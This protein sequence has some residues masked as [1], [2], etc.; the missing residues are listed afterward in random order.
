[1]YD[2]EKIKEIKIKEELWDKE[3]VKK[4]IERFPERK[5]EFKT[6]SSIK[7]KNVYT[8]SDIEGLDY[9]KD[10]SFPG[11]YPF[12]RGVYPNM[13]RGRIWTIRQ[14]AGFGKAEETSGRL[15]FLDNAGQTGLN[16]VFDMPTHFALD[17]DNPLA[18]GEVGRE[19]VA[20]DT[21]E[22]MECL[23]EGIPLDQV[24][25]SLITIGPAAATVLAMYITI[26]EKKG[27]PPEKLAGTLQND[28]ITA[29]AASGA[30]KFEPEVFVRLALDVSEYCIRNMPKWYPLSIVGYHI[31]EAG[32]NAVQELAFT[33][34]SGIAYVKE[35][36]NR[37]LDIDEI[38]PKISFFFGAHNNFF[39]EI[40]KFRAARRM[41][42]QIMKEWFDAKDIRSQV[43]KFHVQ[44]CG[45]TLIAPQ[46]ETNII[47]TT[48]QALA[49]ILG[50]TNSLHTNSM[51]EALALPTEK[52][53]RIAVR[54]QQI[55]AH[56]SGTADVSD[57]LGGSYFVESL[58][59]E[60]EN[61]AYKY[62]EKIDKMGGMIEA[63]KKGF[64]QD[65]I[66]ESA[67]RY[68][69]E[70][71]RGDR[72]VV[73]LNEFQVEEELTLNLLKIDPNYEQ[74][75]KERVQRIRKIRDNTKVK[76]V[77]NDFSQRFHEGENI[78]PLL[79]GAVKTYVTIGEIG[80]IFKEELYETTAGR[81]SSREYI[82]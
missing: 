38:G 7:I 28:S 63:V 59:N 46:P 5:E 18:E 55:I 33:L 6:S 73:G 4:W 68:Q 30:P 19:G 39:E 76:E 49:A 58:T 17:S 15:S 41:W 54:T 66:A 23:F 37:D 74:R 77:L 40:A 70:I 57:P 11:T 81:P 22:D 29:L 65:E 36:L 26:A 42:A 52:A 34:A 9:L 82:K 60:V 13:Y 20:I 35:L 51:D 2:K 48:I 10:L 21:L 56:E 75:Q 50:G 61:K 69:M 32:A 12:T 79:I 31:R 47:R 67:Y 64:I 1:M 80:R 3:L 72:I 45:C 8:P 24:S 44:T 71:E 62:I 53:A 16:I 27:I 78:M 14:V 43:L 25:T